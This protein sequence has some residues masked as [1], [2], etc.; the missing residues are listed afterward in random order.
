M[1]PAPVPVMMSRLPSFAGGV[2]VASIP[3][4]GDGCSR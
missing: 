2:Y 3:E 1:T 4:P